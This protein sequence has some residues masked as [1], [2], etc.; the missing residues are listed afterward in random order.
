M[1]VPLPRSAYMKAIDQF[2][3]DDL[4]LPPPNEID[5]TDEEGR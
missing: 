1:S 4:L 2:P 5:E 3:D